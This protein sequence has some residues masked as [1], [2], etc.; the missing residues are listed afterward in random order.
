MA[1][2]RSWSLSLNLTDGKGF[3]PPL[4]AS[5]S[6]V[7][8]GNNSVSQKQ[9]IATGGWAALNIGLCAS[10]DIIAAVNEDLTNYIQVAS[11]NAGAK[12]FGRLTPGRGILL[13]V[14]P[15]VTIYA[16][17]NAGA[18]WIVLSTAEP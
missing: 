14:E 5:L 17:A 2:T 4:S 10:A 8:A 3:S 16:K 11:D 13:P 9:L 1:L 6:E 7:A 12:I 18:C 15:G